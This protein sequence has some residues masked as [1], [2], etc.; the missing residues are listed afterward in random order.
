MFQEIDMTRTFYVTVTRVA[1][2]IQ[3]ILVD[4]FTNILSYVALEKLQ[5]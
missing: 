1:D 3:L 4:S 2:K 5:C